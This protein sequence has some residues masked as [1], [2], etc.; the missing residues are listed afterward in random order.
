AGLTA[1]ATKAKNWLQQAAAQ[2]DADAK[3][4]LDGLPK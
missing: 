2:N 1:D 4:A 3:K